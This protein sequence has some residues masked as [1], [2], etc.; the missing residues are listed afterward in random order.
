MKK[1]RKIHSR[2][3]LCMALS[4]CL[5]L[6]AAPAFAQSANANLRGQVAGAQAG[7]DV[8]A[9]NVKTGAVR[10]TTT[11]SDGNYT[12]IGLQPGTYRVEAEGGADRA[13]ERGFDRDFELRCSEEWWRCHHS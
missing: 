12:V 5:L 13:V 7:T 1:T 10:H 8:T 6:G 3:A 4:A 9:T 2:H 11:T